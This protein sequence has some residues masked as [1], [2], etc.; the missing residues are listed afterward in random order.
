MHRGEIYT[1]VKQF[2]CT[3]TVELL[4]S[5]YQT[6]SKRPIFNDEN[7]TNYQIIYYFQ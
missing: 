1:T 7:V 4:D 6:V 5:T 3:T 2:Y